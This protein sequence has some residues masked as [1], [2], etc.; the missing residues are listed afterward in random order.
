MEHDQY[1]EL[2]GKEDTYKYLGI[3]QTQ[4]IV[5]GVMKAELTEKFNQVRIRC[6]RENSGIPFEISKLLLFEVMQLQRHIS[7]VVK[8]FLK[9]KDI[10]R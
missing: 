10:N 7:R 5:Q 1:I 2:M 9:F 3:K 8:D 6:R 4:L